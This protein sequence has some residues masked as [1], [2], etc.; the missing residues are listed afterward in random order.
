[1]TIYFDCPRH[2]CQGGLE[3]EY[4]A[5]DASEL[6]VSG[7]VNAACLSKRL[8]NAR[9]GLLRELAR[10]RYDPA[11]RARGGEGPGNAFVIRSIDG[12][13]ENK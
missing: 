11:A 3:Y 1:M 5:M 6:R 13:N 4:D 12:T 2:F 9:R 8:R 10:R 7:G